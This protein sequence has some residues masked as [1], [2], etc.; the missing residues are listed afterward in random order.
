MHGTAVCHWQRLTKYR[1]YMVTWA[2]QPTLAKG[3]WLQINGHV[4]ST[5]AESTS[6]STTTS[7]TTS[8][9]TG[10]STKYKYKVQVQSTSTKYKYK[11]QVE[12][13][14]QVHVQVQVQVQVQVTTHKSDNLCGLPASLMDISIW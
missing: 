3:L 10:T 6:T 11:V 14:Q 7:T 9:S 1:E 13:Q 8:T 2:P 4:S 12:V 5:Q